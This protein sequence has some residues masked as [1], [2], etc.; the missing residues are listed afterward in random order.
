MALSTFDVCSEVITVHGGLLAMLGDTPGSNFIGG[1]KEA[2]GF[3]VR[4]CR[5]CMITSVDLGVK[6]HVHVCC[7][8]NQSILTALVNHADYES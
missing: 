1:F 3:A 7:L 4:K 2:V 6:V 8:H 5:Q